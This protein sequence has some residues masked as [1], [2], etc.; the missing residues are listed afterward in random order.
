MKKNHTLNWYRYVSNTLCIHA[1]IP[2]L[3]WFMPLKKVVEEKRLLFANLYFSSGTTQPTKRVCH[4]PVIPK[5]S[6]TTLAWQNWPC[7]T[8]LCNQVASPKLSFSSTLC[9]SSYL[10]GTFSLPSL[11]PSHLI[12]SLLFMGPSLTR[13]TDPVKMKKKM[14]AASKLFPFYPLVSSFSPLKV[15]K[16]QDSWVW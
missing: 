12:C 4:G 13:V 7:V 8:L 2:L 1:R 6:V 9:P 3:A 14:K 5:F 16:S 10:W 15:T 11:F